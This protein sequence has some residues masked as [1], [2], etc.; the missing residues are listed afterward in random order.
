MSFYLYIDIGNIFNDDSF[1]PT[2]PPKIVS[3]VSG[4]ELV[5]IVLYPISI[6]NRER[7]EWGGG[8]R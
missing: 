3:S 4:A 2:Y 5:I 7:E 6:C 8:S 1:C